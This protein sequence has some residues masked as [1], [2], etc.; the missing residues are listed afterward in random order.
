MVKDGVGLNVFTKITEEEKI[1]IEN[2]GDQLEAPPGPYT[3]QPD[4]PGKSILLYYTHHQQLF[5]FVSGKILWFSG[6]PGMGKSTTAQILARE[7]GFVYYEADCF[8]M[9]KNPYVPLD[10]DNPSVS[11][12]KQ[13]SL[14]GSVIKFKI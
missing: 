7:N 12:M 11:T 10:I 3:I 6:A 2:D 8:G 4:V 14:I 9:L 1:A 13:K 5:I